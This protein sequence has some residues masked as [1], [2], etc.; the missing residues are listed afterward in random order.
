MNLVGH[1]QMSRSAST[2]LT[3]NDRQHALAFQRA[4]FGPHGPEL[5]RIVNIMRGM[6]VKGRY[7]LVCTKPHLEWVL[8]CLPGTKDKAIEIL[9]KQVFTDLATAEWFVFK[10]RWRELTGEELEDG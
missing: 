9:P 5:Q 2:R 3:A 1:N 7:V 4:P 6:P 8:G 10:L